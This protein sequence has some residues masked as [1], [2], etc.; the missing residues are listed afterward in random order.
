MHKQ[1]GSTKLAFINISIALPWRE[2][3]IGRLAACESLNYSKLLLH[4]D[5]VISVE[6]EEHAEEKG[7]EVDGDDNRSGEMEELAP[8][9]VLLCLP[10]T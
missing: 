4:W 7:V 8:K 2:G 10:A 9:L 3:N 5:H 6:P 1:S